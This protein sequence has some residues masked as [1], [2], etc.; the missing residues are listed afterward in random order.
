MAADIA[1]GFSHLGICYSVCL[2]IA[3]QR[4]YRSIHV[5]TSIFTLPLLCATSEDA[6]S[7]GQAGPCS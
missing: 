6:T 2:A 1:I 5:G 4:P 3:Y 7:R